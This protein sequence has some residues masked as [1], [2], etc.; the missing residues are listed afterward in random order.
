MRI[1]VVGYGKMGQLVAQLAPEYDCTVALTLDEH[2]NQNGSGI[3]R[4]AFDGI[5]TAIEFSTPHTA[6]VN[7]ERLAAAGV[8][9]VVGT[10]GWTRDMDRVRAAVD[11]AGT[12]LVWSPNF[13]VGVNVF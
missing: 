12:G 13:S 9:T 1:A 3:T 11:A 8:N 10:T 5:D 7:I 6:L 2:N 4:E